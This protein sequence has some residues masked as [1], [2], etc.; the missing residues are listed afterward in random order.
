MLR[1]L[2]VAF[3]FRTRCRSR[4]SASRSATAKETSRWPLV[5]LESVPP[6]SRN[7]RSMLRSDRGVW[8]SRFRN[9]AMI[10]FSQLAIPAI[11]GR[12]NVDVRSTVALVDPGSLFAPFVLFASVR[13]SPANGPN[14][15]YRF[16]TWANSS[17]GANSSLNSLHFR[18]RRS[19]PSGPHTL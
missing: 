2:A 16:A 7:S 13:T 19:W 14:S 4:I 5:N 18:E 1:V 12:Q 17:T 9:S 3:A 6:A 11:S 10:I 8:S 15:P